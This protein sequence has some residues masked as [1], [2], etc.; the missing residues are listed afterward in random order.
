MCI[1]CRKL[2]SLEKK[3]GFFLLVLHFVVSKVL[4][5]GSVWLDLIEIY[6]HGAWILSCGSSHKLDLIR[7]MV[8]FMQILQRKYGFGV[9]LFDD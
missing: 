3:I 7:L 5:S 1:V 9:S 2:W 6:K 8:W 4:I